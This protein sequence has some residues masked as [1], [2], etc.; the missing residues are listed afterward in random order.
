[1]FTA[2]L[3]VF[4][5]T[6][7][8][9]LSRDVQE[10]Y[11][12][13]FKGLEVAESVNITV[14]HLIRD[15]KNLIISN[16]EAD[17]AKYNDALKAGRVELQQY[18]DDLPKY[19]VTEKG[20]VLVAAMM[21][22]GKEWV[23]V[24]EEVVR[25]GSSFDQERNV[26]AQA[27]SSTNGRVKSTELAEKIKAVVDFKRE[28]A[29]VAA[30]ESA[31]AYANTRLIAIVATLL[32]VLLG[33][34]LGIMVA[35]G[36]V[37][38]LGAEPWAIAE[39]ALRIAGG[40][41][42][43]QFTEK[44]QDIGVFSAIQQMVSML[45]GKIAEAEQKSAEAAEQARLAQIATNEANEAKAR[46]ERAK[47]EGMMQAAQH[48]EGV[49]EVVTSASEELSAQIE[50]SSRGAEEQSTRVSE[51]ATAMEEMNASVLEVAKN[52][53]K[54]ADTSDY[55][56]K[57]AQEGE[58][59]V[60]DVVKGIA[61][62]QRQS[63]VV[64][65]D[66]ATLG[67]QAEGIGQIMNVISDIADQTNLLALNAAIEA[68]RAGDAGR[69]FAVVADE[70]RKLAEKTMAATKEVGEAIRGIQ[71]GTRKSV[72][73]VERSVHTIEEATG[74]ANKSGESLKQIVSL[75]DQSSD[76]VRSIATA[77]EQQ[78]AAS[79]EINRSVEQVA[80]I[81]AQTSQAM[82]EAAKAVAELARQAQ[83]LQGL[84]TQMKTDGAPAKA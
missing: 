42:D 18:L 48:L 29:R 37:R 31:A 28:N 84:I 12:H 3:A 27:L 52:A 64:K 44:S 25:L 56:R 8:K 80:T 49:V 73:G 34:G 36:T 72:E 14:L 40:D 68:A 57:Q 23:K 61:E 53:Q 17:L 33:V 35:R 51:T 4:A 21:A 43:A 70:V 7:L 26:Q 58:A 10:L 6:G 63:L 62:V 54:A 5:L 83:V 59:I 79:E 60:D 47:A 65:E 39:H 82:G 22:A 66:M 15:E 24:H 67:K 75:V 78:S 30:Q 46:A 69:G 1:M 9:G 2:I 13:D 74:L 38:Q 32:S 19:F 50:Q 76:Q 45:K 81:S 55:A 77:S 41:L 71:T 20:K 16:N 11:A